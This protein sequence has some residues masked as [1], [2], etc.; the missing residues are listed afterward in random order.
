VSFV[1][2]LRRRNHHPKAI[3]ATSA[4][5]PITPPTIAPTG[6]EDF[7]LVGFE[8]LGC[9]FGELPP[10]VIVTVVVGVLDDRVEE[11]VGVEVDVCD[12]WTDNTTSS[13]DTVLWVPSTADRNMVSI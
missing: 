12:A 1:L 7:V 5:P 9:E 10:G 3:A 2:L 8:L 4:M 11:D 6:V 13:I